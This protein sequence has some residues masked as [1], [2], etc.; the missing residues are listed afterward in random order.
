MNK[1]KQNA[2]D[3]AMERQDLSKSENEQ[4][5][6]VQH[7]AT[8]EGYDPSI[9]APEG[10]EQ[11]GIKNDYEKLNREAKEVYSSERDYHKKMHDA[12]LKALVERIDAIE[13]DEG[14]KESMIEKLHKEFDRAMKDGPYFPLARFGQY[15]VSSENAQ[16]VKSFDMF[17]NEYSQK[18]FVE[19]LK[20]DPNEEVVGFGKNLDKLK[21]VDGVSGQFISDV[22][23]LIRKG[24]DSPVT[25]QIRDDVFQLYLETLPELSA[26]KKY[27]HRGKVKG[28]AKDQ[29][30]AF[31]QKARADAN[32]VA[33]LRHIHV[34]QRM[35]DDTETSLNIASSTK[36][37]RQFSDHVTALQDAIENVPFGITDFEIQELNEK[38]PFKVFALNETA[39]PEKEIKR[40]LAKEKT[41]LQNAE[42][43]TEDK[44]TFVANGLNELKKSHEAM[45]NNQTHPIASNLNSLGFLWYLGAS[46]AAALVNL[47]QTPT[48]A[49]PM[50]L[51]DKSLKNSARYLAG[52][53][54]DFI[55]GKGTIE[56]TLNANERKAFNEWHDS[57][58]LENTQ[59]HDLSGVADS[60]IDTG[61]F[62]NKAMRMISF[63]FHRAEVMNREVTA[64]ATYRAAMAGG[65]THEQAVKKGADLTWNSHLDYGASNRARFM[66]GN[67]MRVITQFKQYSQGITYIYAK[68]LLDTFKGETKQD[69]QQA[70]KLLG[71][72]V[73]SQIAVAGTLGLPMAGVVM[74]MAQ[75]LKDA[76]DDD[77]EATSVKAEFRQAM[78]NFAGK[79]GGQAISHGL[80]DAFTPLSMSGRLSMADL[81]IRTP[82]FD[83]EGKAE[84]LSYIE[85]LGGPMVSI[86]TNM[87]MGKDSLKDGNFMRAAEQMTPKVVKDF[88]RA[89]RYATEGNLTRAGLK[90][91]DMTPA[92][93]IAQTLGFSSSEVSEI[94]ERATQIKNIEKKR[95]TRRKE[96]IDNWMKSDDRDMT[97]IQAWNDKYPMDRITSKT[98]RAARKSKL[99]YASQVVKGVRRTKR[100]ID[101]IEEYD[102]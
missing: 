13:A 20:A 6:K 79:R 46:P 100:N 29:A 56:P 67:T 1:M 82:D 40:V 36:L 97:E 28:Y 2:G 74:G 63:M 92:E 98:L 75:G 66:R 96:I 19:E 64:L 68:T 51:A 3:I 53:V 90:I 72:L 24:G 21:T 76:F 48:V 11:E 80:I 7:E 12:R 88:M 39:D 25:Q 47:T 91:K 101:L 44:I 86:F 35:I 61:T 89:T 34:L 17:E 4:L 50:M 81:W 22:D 55:A 71:M 99:R 5:A 54:K 84:A 83:Q 77:D 9:K 65:A 43:I 31:A 15:W 95:T 32:D 85:A 78:A 69:R 27:L 26:R 45:V 94:R 49:L 60:G 52:A 14:F 18:R 70:M 38:A 33:R 58:L 30:R 93:M 10:F 42:K 8:I 73:S 37:K 41:L 57:G 23:K 102:F 87:F 62:K 16:G 59:A